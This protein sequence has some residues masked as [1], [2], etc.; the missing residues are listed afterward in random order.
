MSYFSRVRLNILCP[1]FR[2]LFRRLKQM[3]S[4]TY[5]DIFLLLGV[6]LLWC[7]QQIQNGK[8]MQFTNCM[9]A[10]FRLCFLKNNALTLP[11][12][13]GAKKKALQ[14]EKCSSFSIFHCG[15]SELKKPGIQNYS[16]AFC[17]F[18]L[19]VALYRTLDVKRTSHKNTGMISQVYLLQH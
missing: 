14:E 9:P 15:A 6:L 17:L 18:V 1:F 10:S 7:F 4:V 19:I 3:L 8:I 5:E 16:G 13:C 11:G 12:I 2:Q